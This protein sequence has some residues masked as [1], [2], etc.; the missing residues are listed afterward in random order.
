MKLANWIYHQFQDLSK[1]GKNVE[2]AKTLKNRN[3]SAYQGRTN[4]TTTTIMF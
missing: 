1:W 3:F 4:N 2:K